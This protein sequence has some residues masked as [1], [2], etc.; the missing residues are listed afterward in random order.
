MKR[1]RSLLVDYANAAEGEG[2]GGASMVGRCRLIRL[3]SR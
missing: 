2:N 1:L 3:N